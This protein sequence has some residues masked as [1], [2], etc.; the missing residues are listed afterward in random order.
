MGTSVNWSEGR[1]RTATQERGAQ[2]H[3]QTRASS[4]DADQENKMKI[5]EKL[6]EC[7]KNGQVYFSFEYFP[8]KTEEG[9]ANLFPRMKKMVSYGPQFCDI[10]WGA[11]GSTTDLTQDIANRMQKEVGIE[12]MMHLTCTNMM[13]EKVTVALE[14]CKEAGIENILALRG[15]P[16]KG[17]EKWEAVEGGFE[18]ALDLVKFIREKHGDFFGIGVAGYP[19]AH[20]DA[21]CDDPE[22]FAKNYQGELEYLKKK[23]DAGGQMIITQL[24]YDVG[25]FL[26]FVKDCRNIGINCPIL[27]G[28]MPIQ[29]YG[30]FMRMTGFCKTK[31]P[32]EILD[33]L[34][35]IKDN[36]EAVKAYGIH[37]GTQMCKTLI[38]AGTPGLHMYSLNQDK[39]VLGILNGLG[40][41]SIEEPT[42]NPTPAIE[43]KKEEEKATA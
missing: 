13:P 3:T 31:V 4:T 18:C 42:K 24:F 21:I 33:T 1:E 40:L 32:Q 29:S 22:Q 23:I 11:G 12:T 26:Q 27:P 39:A 38:E 36:A 43:D 35:P 30:G 8:P 14:K 25:N 41:I 34:E 20:P 9:I 28:I 37:L 7:S 17:Q 6:E 5:A 2:T 16:P 15:D 19:E 10:T